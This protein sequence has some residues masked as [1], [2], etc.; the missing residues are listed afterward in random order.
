MLTVSSLSC[1][2]AGSGSGAPVQVV[3]MPGETD[4]LMFSGLS[5][6]RTYFRI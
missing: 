4:A 2:S 6:Q 5:F 1:G 3:A